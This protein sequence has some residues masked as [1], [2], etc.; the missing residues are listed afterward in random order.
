MTTITIPFEP[1]PWQQEFVDAMQTKKRAVLVIHRR[2]GKDL[3]CWNWFILKALARKGIY[4]YI[5]PEYSQGRKIVWDGMDEEGFGYIDYIPRSL[6]AKRLNNEMKILLKN[7]SLIQIVGSDRFDTLRGTNPFGVVLSEYAFQNPVVWDSI[8]QPILQKNNGWAVF[9]STPF[10]QNH[11]YDKYL[12]AKANPEEWYSTFLTIKDTG[13]ISEEDI[14][15]KK[16]SGEMSEEA[17]AREYYCSFTAGLTGVIYNKYME[18]AIKEKRIGNI[19]WDKTA[20]VNTAWDL[21]ISK[22]DTTAIIFYQNIGNEIHIIDDYENYNEGWP[23]YADILKNK[24]YIYETHFAPHDI[25][26]KELSS[27]LSRVFAAKNI[28]IEFTIL[29]TL[30][31]SV[32]EGIEAARSIFPRVWIDANKAK[33]LIK[34]L[35]N[36]RRKYDDKLGIYGKPIHDWASHFA[37]SFRYL[38]IANKLNLQRNA[39]VSD[40]EAENM[41][42]RYNPRFN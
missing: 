6:I 36:Y 10:G 3:I 30:K 21:G 15:K 26:N 25:K 29:P 35:S 41:F 31:L 11:F 27:G 8:L 20:K 32:E 12:I 22:S 18:E 19:P 33:R 37:D 7:G 2:G 40:R 5:F 14:Q 4:Y 42:K 13:L 24:P 1:Y 39:G 16:D 34:C 9:N 17:I 23:H 28:G 38:S